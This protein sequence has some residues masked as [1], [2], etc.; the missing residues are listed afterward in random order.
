MFCPPH[1]ISPLVSFQRYLCNEEW[2]FC[3]IR[4]CYLKY[5]PIKLLRA[6]LILY[7]MC[8]L[9]AFQF[10]LPL[11]CLGQ[12]F[13]EL[14]GNEIGKLTQLKTSFLS[15]GYFSVGTHHPIWY[16]TKLLIPVC[17]C[18]F[19]QCGTDKHL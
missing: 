3:K 5:S 11:N 15:L 12:E 6:N 4:Q 13:V 19:K 18:S 8:S 9:V 17:S 16:N 7:P 1:S 10:S 2:I 14:R